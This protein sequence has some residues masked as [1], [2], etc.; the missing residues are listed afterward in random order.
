MTGEGVDNALEYW[1]EVAARLHQTVVRVFDIRLRP[2]NLVLVK[3]KRGR[4]SARTNYSDLITIAVS[5]CREKLLEPG[6]PMVSYGVAHEMGHIV[7]GHVAPEGVLPPVVWDEIWAHYC[8]IN[9]FL[10]EI[11][12]IRSNGGFVQELPEEFRWR[13]YCSFH[14]R[15]L[16][17]VE[18]SLERGYQILHEVAKRGGVRHALSAVIALCRPALS[19]AECVS[20]LRRFLG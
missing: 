20:L 8:A 5:E 17:T 18:W 1:T 10:P 3:A 7:L 14:S 13:A 9:V 16:W 11:V 19:S 12:S 2:G 4:E 6:D 15:S